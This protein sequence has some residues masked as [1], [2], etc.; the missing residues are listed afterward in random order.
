MISIIKSFVKDKPLMLTVQECATFIL[1]YGI[2][3]KLFFQELL[4]F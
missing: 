3:S 1:L 2:L 4:I